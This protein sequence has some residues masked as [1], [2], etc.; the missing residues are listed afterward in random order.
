VGR[1]RW[2]R[3]GVGEP[4][5]DQGAAQH[6]LP[7]R[8][9]VGAPGRPVPPE[10]DRAVDAGQDLV[11]AEPVDLDLVGQLVG[12]GQEGLVAGAQGGGGAAAAHLGLDQ[13]EL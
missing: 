10:A 7:V 9:I 4:F 11:A 3:W 6:L 13:G 1:R 12:E 8:P 5:E 2:R